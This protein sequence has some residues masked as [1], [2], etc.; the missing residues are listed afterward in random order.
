MC[1]GIVDYV[2]T[3][4]MYCEL[5]RVSTA[6]PLA[7]PILIERRYEEEPWT[8]LGRCQQIETAYINGSQIG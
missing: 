7:A 5:H 4:L 2:A 1:D 3:M 8:Q 6:L